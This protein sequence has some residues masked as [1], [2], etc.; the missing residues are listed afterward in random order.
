MKTMKTQPEAPLLPPAQSAQVLAEH[1]LAGVDQDHGV[2]FDG[3]HVWFAAGPE[4]DLHCVEPASGKLVRRL[5]RKDC[6]A[7]L[8]FDGQH[9]WQVCDDGRI[10]CIE[11]ASGRT[12]RSVPVPPGAHPSGLAWA[13]GSLWLGDFRGRAIHKLDPADGKVLRTIRSERLVT[14]VTWAGAELW[15]GTYPESDEAVEP[16]EL[17]QIDAE[18]GA[19]RK[20]LHLAAGTRISGTE[21]DGKDRI[22]LGSRQGRD[23]LRAVRKP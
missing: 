14:G 18:T 7:G 8:A 11:R 10:H 2:T 15:H 19:V 6:N 20:R 22:W 17:R 23:T 9:L 12:L 13:A 16:G 21:F 3:A 1:A 5:G 4:G